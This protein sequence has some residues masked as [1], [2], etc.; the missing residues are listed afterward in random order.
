[1]NVSYVISSLMVGGAERLLVNVINNI[2]L[3]HRVQVILFKEPAPL[4]DAIVRPEVELVRLNSASYFSWAAI[5]K[6]VRSVRAFRPD[7]VH[8]HMNSSNLIIRMLRPLLSGGMIL[9]NQYHGLS[10]W[11]SKALTWFD[12]SSAFLVDRVI[13]C[14]SASLARRADSERLPREKLV[15]LTNAVDLRPFRSRE[16][17]AGS[18]WV[19]GTACRLTENKRVGKLLEWHAALLAAGYD[20]HC[21]IAGDGPE[22]EKLFAL[23]RKLGHADRVRFLGQVGDMAGFYRE[24]DVF[25]LSS[26]LEDLPMVLIEAMASGCATASHATGGVRDVLD[27]APGAAVVDLDSDGWMVELERLLLRSRS[28]EVIDGNRAY[29]RQYGMDVYIDRLFDVYRAAG[30][31]DAAQS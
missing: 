9:V 23:A 24:L 29:A 27:G 26:K 18:P 6:L 8:T 15:L 1:M 31:G 21:R 25:L 4:V 13:C 16:P 14:S 7:V 30:A 22:R 19:I 12:R 3:E 17:V 20:V 2:P 11:K 10:L 28:P 5:S